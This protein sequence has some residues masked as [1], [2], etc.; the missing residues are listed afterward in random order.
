MFDA[1]SVSLA[2]VRRTFGMNGCV[3]CLLFEHCGGHPLPLI[4]QLGCVNYALGHTVV[5]TDDMTPHLPERFWQLWNDVGGLF[6]YSTGPLKPLKAAGLPRYLPLLQHRH[7]RRSQ[8]FPA[9]VVALR[10]FDVV[11][12]RRTGRYG[13]AFSTAAELRAAYNLRPDAQVLLVGVDP[14]PPLE[15]F[16]AEHRIQHIGESLAQLDLLGVTVPNFSFFTCVPRFQ[17][18]RNRKRILL[19]A[20]R[21]SAAG[22]PV[23]VHLNAY[24]KGD[25]DFWLGYLR[26]HP[27]CETVALEFQTGYRTDEEGQA[28]FES[29]VSLRNQLGRRIHPILVGCGRFYK[30]ASKEFASFTVIDSQPFMQTIARQVLRPSEN[31]RFVWQHSPTLANETLGGLFDHN[32]RC[33]E[34]KFLTEVDNEMLEQSED[35]NQQELDFTSTPYL[36]DHPLA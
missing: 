22:V 5:D 27:E 32:V 33:Y 31:G 4:R 2:R 1:T 6:D 13:P 18:M 17:I 15:S 21:L 26:D 19:S 10:L 8:P 35:S 12:R 3:N 11:R 16:W 9:P 34:T 30:D 24:T 23:A 14:D 29:L 20:E 28:A 25:W 7:L 36:T